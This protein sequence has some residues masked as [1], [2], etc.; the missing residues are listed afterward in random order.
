[1]GVPAS[2]E[3]MC[4]E[5]LPGGHALKW[6]SV[7]EGPLALDHLSNSL[8]LGSARR[9]GG[10]LNTCAADEEEKEAASL[11]V[12]EEMVEEEDTLEWIRMRSP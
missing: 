11:E 12:E 2:G 7:W 3:D 8:S 9:M 5:T 10:E 6:G 1:M 4:P